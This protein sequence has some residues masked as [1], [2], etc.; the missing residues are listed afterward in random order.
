M[1]ANVF[2][3]ISFT[4]I[5]V[6]VQVYFLISIISLSISISKLQIFPI[7]C[8]LNIFEILL[9]NIQNKTVSNT[10]MPENR[11]LVITKGMCSLENLSVKTEKNIDFC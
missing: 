3:L 6:T 10:I 11:Y 4:K 9:T 1:K 8:H 5:F 2:V 7:L